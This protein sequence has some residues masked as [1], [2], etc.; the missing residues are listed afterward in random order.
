MYGDD[1]S[2]PSRRH[3]SRYTRDEDIISDGY[4]SDSLDSRSASEDGGVDFM[5]D[6]Y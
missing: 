5:D 1:G 6:E 3:R 4:D 2:V